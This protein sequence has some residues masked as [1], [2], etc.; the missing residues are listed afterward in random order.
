MGSVLWLLA[1]L[2]FGILAGRHFFTDTGG[3]KGDF[4]RFLPDDSSSLLKALG[5][6]L[7]ALLLLTLLVGAINEGPQ[8]FFPILILG[9]WLLAPIKVYLDAKERGARAVAWA[10]LTLIM[11]LAFFGYLVARPDRPRSCARCGVRLREEF[12]VCPYCGPQAGMTCVGCRAPLE[13]DWIYCPFCHMKTPS[14]SSD[15]RDGDSGYGGDPFDT[16]LKVI[17]VP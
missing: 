14:G 10:L 9:L 6:G 5:Y 1:A 17:G 12:A 4:S 2:F 3:M 16:P 15:E 13:P 8:V 11:P 7:T